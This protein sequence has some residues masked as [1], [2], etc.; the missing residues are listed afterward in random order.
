M[1]FLIESAEVGN[2][3]LKQLREQREII[4]NSDFVGFLFLFLIITYT[5]VAFFIDT[6]K[7]PLSRR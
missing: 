3:G 7:Y 1:S 2:I 4:T 6:V 5:K